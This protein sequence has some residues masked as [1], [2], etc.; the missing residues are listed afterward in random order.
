LATTGVFEFDGRRKSDSAREARDRVASVFTFRANTTRACADSQHVKLGAAIGSIG[1]EG[2][3]CDPLTSGTTPGFIAV[4][5]KQRRGNLLL[6]SQESGKV[7]GVDRDGN[8]LRTLAFPYLPTDS[9][10][11]TVPSGPGRPLSVADQQH[12]GITWDDV[13]HTC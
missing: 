7:I 8:I 4:K 6:L 1:I 9:V 5:A 12:E 10:G 11:T 3:S 13:G 2:I